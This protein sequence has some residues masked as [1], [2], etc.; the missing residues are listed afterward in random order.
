MYCL[1]VLPLWLR[2]ALFIQ[3]SHNTN[4]CS[5]S[6][7]HSR[8]K[9][10]INVL[11]CS[12]SK[13]SH[14]HE[15]HS[16]EKYGG[17]VEFLWVAYLEAA[18]LLRG[19]VTFALG[20]KKEI[21]Y[22]HIFYSCG[23]PGN[24]PDPVDVCPRLVDNDCS[25][26]ATTSCSHFG[27]QRNEQNTFVTVELG[28]DM[29]MH[30]FEANKKHKEILQS[31]KL[32]LQESVKGSSVFTREQ[33]TSQ[34]QS[35][36]LHGK[37]QPKALWLVRKYHVSQGLQ[38]GP[39]VP[40]INWCRKAWRAILCQELLCH[41]FPLLAIDP[42]IASSSGRLH[43]TNSGL[44]F[45]VPVWGF[46]WI[47]MGLQEVIVSFVTWQNGLSCTKGITAIKSRVS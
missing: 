31:M 41:V 42:E 45:Q 8:K 22:T 32:V 14:W 35:K 15:L 21:N 39:T 11:K 23:S 29:S 30:I 44:Y 6:L 2:H 1:A 16:S 47:W 13:C 43:H 18:Q 38:T 24:N 10:V 7:T 17:L 28:K 26:L 4:T 12:F 19:Q 27:Q 46:T 20:T 25:C 3:Q 33:N 9:A 40:E 36:Q 34:G 5:D 37:G